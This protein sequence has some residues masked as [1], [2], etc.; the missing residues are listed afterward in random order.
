MIEKELEWNVLKKI[1]PVVQDNSAY[2]LLSRSAFEEDPRK[3]IF[4]E[5]LKT[6]MNESQHKLL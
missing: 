6:E 4:L 3:I 1:S 2:F 5:W